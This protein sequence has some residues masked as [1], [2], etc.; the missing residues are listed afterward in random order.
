M[1]CKLCKFLFVLCTVFLPETAVLAGI[2]G[3]I[4]GMVRDKETGQVL[5]G[6]QIRVEGT[7]TGAMA[8]KNGYYIINNL[9]AGVYDVSVT[10]IG[11]A[12][13][14]IRNVQVSVDLNTQLNFELVTQV[15]PLEEVVIKDK[16]TLIH[17]D[18]TS[19][20]YFVSGEEINE[21]LP[22][23]SYRQAISL[24]PGIVGNHFR[25]GRETDVVY[26]LDGL[27]IQ[28]SLSREIAS[29]FPNGSIVEM[30]VQ[31]GG[32]A[33]EYGNAT[34]GLVNVVTNEG[35]NEVE[36][37]IKFYSDFFK[38]GLT[39]NDNTRRL[40]FNVGGPMTIGFGGPLLH[41]N[42]FVAA[43]LNVSDTAFGDQ[44]RQAFDSP[45][46]KN[47]NINSKLSFDLT[48]NTL[49]TFQGL[50]SNW[51]WRTFDPQWELNLEGLAQKK[52]N[53]HRFS[54]S[55][56]H[57]FSPRWFASLRLARYGYKRLV[58]GASESDAAVVF[59]DPTDPTS[60]VV[61]GTQPWDEESKE[62]INLLKVDFVG[63]IRNGHLL[64]TGL[65]VQD[66]DVYS[67]S[68]RV[69]YFSAIDRKGIVFNR[70]A[71]KVRY[72][73][74]IFSM[75]VQDRI[76]HK[77][78]TANLGVR[79]DLFSPNVTIQQ[80]SD[81]F[82]ELQKSLGVTGTASSS[83]MTPTVS[84][85]L[86]LSFPLSDHERLHVN[87]G[88]YYQLPALYYYFVNSDPSLQGYLPLV[89]N[90]DLAPTKT[91]SSEFSYKR[92]VNEDLLFV[93]TGFVKQFHNLVDTRTFL[94]SDTTLTGQAETV[95][96]S[97]YTNSARGQATGFEVMLQK[98]FT[99]NLAGRISY[100]YMKATGTSST[101]EENHKLAIEGAPPAEERTVQFPLS[102]DQRHSLIVH[103]DFAS[104]WLNLNALYRLFSP[105]PF[106]TPGSSVPNDARL[107]W[108]H[109][110]DVKVRLRS[111]RFLGGDLVPF[112]E[113]RNLFDQENVVN[114]P[115]D[116]GVRAYRL[117]DPI[118]SNLGRRFR[119]G[120]SLNY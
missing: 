119:V 40:E 84:P 78:I 82:Q 18:I 73:P 32:Y 50:I 66:Y 17:R 7:T 42:Y 35:R 30:V 44:M 92:V 77:G 56:T 99:S 117:F 61:S 23:D 65:E 12:K 100:T 115:D 11:Y 83:Q 71:H 81:K 21:K 5:P 49:L 62:S 86:G 113:I 39:G 60:L 36:A 75:Y 41:A 72:S 64:K 16:R 13:V 111:Y 54:V 2:T 120:F 90:V 52:H 105:L 107:S 53:S 116:S 59:D 9:P 70:S 76:E 68:V 19:S 33:A 10:M 6:A 15:L 28:G 98:R 26:L 101:A 37:Q 74:R 88:W 51:S 103:V 45:I 43:D 67:N 29:Y 95:G 110:F 96:F 46:F 109:I 112:F 87:Y 57:T 38:T 69:D 97:Q 20:T 34:S 1:S 93:L 24:L 114:Q 94:I 3:T 91:I 48:S 8:D 4:S 31:T 89:G 55:L 102:W 14:T 27:P 47:L 63:R 108:R 58:E 104:R 106:T 22:V 25:G 85:R 80:Q 79:Y 118:N